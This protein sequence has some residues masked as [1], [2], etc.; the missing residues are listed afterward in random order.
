MARRPE[1]EKDV[2]SSLRWPAIAVRVDP[3][4]E[5]QLEPVDCA[6]RMSV[7][8]AVC[9]RLKFALSQDEIERGHV[10]WDIGHP[11]VIR[12]D[13]SGYCSHNDCASR[14]CTIYEDRPR[15][16]R[17]YSCRNDKRIWADF[18]AMVLNT[19][20]INQHLGEGDAILLVDADP[21]PEEVA[22]AAGSSVSFT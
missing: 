15:L 13:S 3:A 10:K 18:D 21:S 22:P 7:C 8:Q 2:R 4:E 17:E 19:E 20:W 12:Q 6:A 9:C 5:T 16:C 1:D 11:Y 14:S